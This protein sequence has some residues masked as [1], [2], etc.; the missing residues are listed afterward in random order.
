M[1]AS[2]QE[3]ARQAALTLVRGERLDTTTLAGELGVSRVTLFRRA[4]NRDA[5]LGEA[6]WLMTR[7]TLDRA[8]RDHDRRPPGAEAAGRLRCLAVTED[9]R[10]AVSSA[11][12]LRRLLE[13]EPTTTLRI[14]TDPR[15]RVQPR[16]VDAYAELFQRDVDEFGL[17]PQV[18]VPLLAFGVVRLG[19]SFLYSDVMVSRAPDLKAATTVLDALVTGVLGRP[20]S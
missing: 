4:G 19:E 2:A 9:F 1:I 5:I 12:P 3:V 18:P 15:G 16:L 8:V 14:V 11:A 20:S 10:Y 7:R 13:E 6:L 17:L